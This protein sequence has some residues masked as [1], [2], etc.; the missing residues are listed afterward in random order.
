[1]TL[2]LNPLRERTLLWLLALTQFTV[3]LSPGQGMS[4]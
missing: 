3:V 4:T 2:T 1:M